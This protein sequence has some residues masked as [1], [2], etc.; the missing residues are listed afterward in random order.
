MTYDN[1]EGYSKPF[2]VQHNTG[3]GVMEDNYILREV[4]GE[5]DTK[6]D[7]EKFADKL[8]KEN[9]TLEQIKS[10]WCDNTYCVNVNTLSEKG[11]QLLADLKKGFKDIEIN[12][13]EYDTYK[14]G[15]YTFYFKKWDF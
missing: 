3:T 13:D 10:T 2:I 14:V 1:Y 8:F 15:E 5:F 4:A 6:E 12:K 7:A 11:K 9:N